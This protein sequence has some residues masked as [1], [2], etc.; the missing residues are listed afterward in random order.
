MISSDTTAAPLQLSGVSHRYGN[1]PVLDQVDLQVEPGEFVAL[2]GPSG[3]G[4]TT[5]L[6]SV[7]GLVTP[8]EGRIDI[9]GRVVTQEG[10]V[11]IPTENRGVG[12][13]FQESTHSS[14]I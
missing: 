12:L 3:C 10:E 1:T 7:A 6:R 2:L 14:P 11:R 13:V 9:D 5:L 8:Q 4:K